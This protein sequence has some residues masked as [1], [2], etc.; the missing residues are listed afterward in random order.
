MSDTGYLNC[1]P[2]M[3]VSVLL[4]EDAKHDKSPKDKYTA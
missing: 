1:T 2:A 3:I 4:Q